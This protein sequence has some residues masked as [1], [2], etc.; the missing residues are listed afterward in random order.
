M[1][2]LGVKLYLVVECWHWRGD[3]PFSMLSKRQVM[4]LSHH[5][6]MLPTF[7]AT[8]KSHSFL[9]PNLF[10]GDLFLLC[11]V[12]ESFGNDLGPNYSEFQNPEKSQEFY[13]ICVFCQI[14][15]KWEWELY[16]KNPW[17]LQ[18]IAKADVFVD[19]FSE[20][21]QNWSQTPS[22][23]LTESM[24]P[25]VCPSHG[26]RQMCQNGG[27]N[28]PPPVGSLNWIILMWLSV[29]SNHLKNELL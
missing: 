1:K 13:K 5:W 3:I 19:S 22:A 6:N 4:Y 9:L 2:Q 18:I 17:N 20:H 16:R 24:L 14:L 15:L 11:W 26:E 10:T 12:H 7:E 27:V 28:F 23:A 8:S 29:T 21:A 25:R